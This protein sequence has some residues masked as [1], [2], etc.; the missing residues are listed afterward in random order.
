MHENVDRVVERRRIIDLLSYT[1]N[2][3]AVPPCWEDI[4]HW[5][6]SSVM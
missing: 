2:Y 1:H 4:E 3:F 5:N 6:E